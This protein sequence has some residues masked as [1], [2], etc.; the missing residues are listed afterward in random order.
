MTQTLADRVAGQMRAEMARR[1][2]TASELARRLGEVE[3]WV[4]RRMQGRYAI[5][6][7]DLER[8][9]R[10]LDLPVSFFIQDDN[11]AAA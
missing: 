5:N 11:E 6:I 2:I 9:A 1:R 10:A 7:T 8:I 4:R 3:S